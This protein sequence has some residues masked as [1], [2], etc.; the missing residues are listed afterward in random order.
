MDP[1]C[2]TPRVIQL[3]LELRRQSTHQR[4]PQCRHSNQQCQHDTIMADQA[5]IASSPRGDY[6]VSVRHSRHDPLRPLIQQESAAFETSTAAAI[7]GKTVRRG[8][9]ERHDVEGATQVSNDTASKPTDFE[10]LVVVGQGAFGKVRALTSSS[11]VNIRG[12]RPGD[13]SAPQANGGDLR[14][15]S[16]IVSKEYLVKKNYIGNMQTERDIM[17]KVDHPFLVKLK[18]AFQTPANVYL[19]MPYIPGGELFHTLH[20]QG[21]L[22]EHTACFYAAEMVLALEYLHGQGIIHRDLKPENI[23]LDADGHVCLTDFGLSKELPQDDEAKTVCGTNGTALVHVDIAIEPSVLPIEYM[24]PEMIRNKPYS[25]AVDWWALGALIYEMVTG[26]PP[27]RHNNRKKLLEKICTEKLSL[28]K[29]LHADTHSILKQLLERNVDKRLGAGKST[30]FKVK[31]VA[32]IKQHP[33]FSVQ[34]HERLAM[35]FIRVWCVAHRLGSLGS[36]KDHA[37]RDTLVGD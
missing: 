4:A 21:L 1:N 10:L 32:A 23:L 33:F 35:R 16:T 8:S 20:K 34:Q 13:S 36:T 2:F 30:M 12:F 18:Y 6:D 5:A 29:F 37:A 26:Y 17:T 11:F 19:V 25:H 28:P 24:A 15:E 3:S 31:G 9:K 22:L 14:H 27:F 7:T